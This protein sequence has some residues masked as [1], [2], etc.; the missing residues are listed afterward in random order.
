MLIYENITEAII[1]INSQ[2]KPLALYLFWQ[3]QVLHKHILQ[4]IYFGRV[5]FNNTLRQYYVF[6][7][8]EG[9]CW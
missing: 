8:H 1:K 7:L 2:S 4:K 6:T 3:N 9:W 5:C